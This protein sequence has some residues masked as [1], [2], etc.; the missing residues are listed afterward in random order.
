MTSHAGDNPRDAG[1][2]DSN[3][4]TEMRTELSETRAQIGQLTSLVQQLMKKQEESGGPGRGAANNN[5]SDTGRVPQQ[6]EATASASM[7]AAA[8]TAPGGE[9]RRSIISSAGS[10]GS[11]P[12]I[13]EWWTRD[14]PAGA[15]PVTRM[16]RGEARDQNPAGITTHDR[17]EGF[18]AGSGGEGKGQ[19]TRVVAPVLSVGKFA[20]WKRTFE[21]KANMLDLLERF[22]EEGPRV[23]PVGGTHLKTKRQLMVEG[24]SEYEIGEERKA[25]NFIDKALKSETDRVALDRCTTP[26]EVLQYL[27]RLHDPESEVA[28][29]KRFDQF[30]DFVIPPNSN[31]VTALHNLE[32][33]NTLMGE[34]GMES[35][36]DT[37]LHARFVRALP[38]EYSNTKETLQ[39]MKNRT[40][41]EIVRMVGARYSNLPAKK[42][43]HRSSRA[44]D[45]AFLSGEGGDRGGSRRGRGGNRGGQ[46]RGRGG[47]NGSDRGSH[48]SSSG[49]ENNGSGGGVK[50]PPSRCFRCNRKGHFRGDCTTKESDFIIRCA[51]CEG[52][53]HTEDKC[54]SDTAVLVM[55]LPALT[56]EEHAVE[57]QAFAAVD[58]TGKCSV[59]N[60]TE[61]GG[62][63]MD[64]QV[65]QYV[66]DSAATC[67]LTPDADGLT[68]YQECSRPLGLANGG[69]IS[70]VGYGDLTVAFAT[71]NGWVH[72]T[73]R[74]VAHA[75]LLEY[76]LISLPSIALQGHTYAGDKDGVTL[77]LTGGE[78]VHFPL[79][80]KL[81]RQYGYRPEA[82]GSMVDT[83]CAT[84]APGQAK[85]PTTP[86]DVNIFHCT[87]GH[88]HEVL[89]KKT[90]AQQGVKLSGDFHECHGCSM[91]KGLRK[92]I[93]RSTHTRAVKKLQ[94]V[95]VDL[96]GKMTV[97]SIGGKWYTLI[98]RDDCT[99]FT[100]VY[101]LRQKSDA[102]SAFESF[103]AEVRAD[104]IP[105]EVVIVRSDN[106]G[107][108]FGGD[109]GKLCRTRGIKQEFTPADTPK[110]NGVAERA[111]ALMI[112]AALAARLQ[113]PVL[114]PGAPTYPSLWAE[115]MS[116]ACHVMN[117]T[118]TTA[119]PGDKS[120]YEMWHGS[121]PPAG[122]VWPFLKPAVCT[123]KR[124]NK[125]QPKGQ[126]CYYLGPGVD[127]PRDCVRVLTSHRTVLTTRNLT[128]QHVPSVPPEPP[129][130][131]PP[132]EEEG[133]SEAG[134][135]E[136]GEGAS[137]QGGGRV[138]DDDDDGDNGSNDNVGSGSGLDVTEAG[139]PMPPAARVAP[140]EDWKDAEGTSPGSP[141][142][143]GGANLGGR[144]TTGDDSS[145]SEQQQ[146]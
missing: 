44:P 96:S 4:V 136:S 82:T 52:F 28:T 114:Y 19:T 48:G 64:K 8:A 32:S 138:D 126:D 80:G 3:E 71:D 119:N 84:I 78:N 116:W 22:Q 25:M 107:E 123:V 17:S 94:R 69:T 135:G 18:V 62:G 57:A 113:A 34:K 1:D 35:L 75:P 132:I 46:G 9:D 130:Q 54:I 139:F 43:S 2:N 61:V 83:A 86:T 108:F 66:A 104:G 21:R 103:L 30:H 45:Q 40:R 14:I 55:E 50:R 31:P 38:E 110:Y 13:G 11:R 128:W 56:E 72:V 39:S 5:D 92:P 76:H 65:M 68:N 89:L 145:S 102:A 120:P 140:A 121:P 134:E 131:L 59:M 12:P 88:T 6:Q 115:S 81:C 129:Q 118:A 127:H 101:F 85:A 91:A 98:V 73:M 79:I 37:F 137:S 90:A 60:G 16:G 144:D 27:Q 29:Q 42:G 111:L 23:V 36:P 124:K 74:E 67:H 77:E 97:S 26:R 99:R 143:G 63:A 109:F 141:S 95:F 133:E 47:R 10:G 112:D 70:I 87:Y 53:G 20:A 7:G 105:S 125:S 93:A 51:R 117:L 58:A 49:G 41:D 24:F 142:P 100:R 33:L 122:G 15:G 146:Q 106:G